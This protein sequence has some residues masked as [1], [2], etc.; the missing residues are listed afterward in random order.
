MTEIENVVLGSSGY[1]LY[2]SV[3]VALAAG[4]ANIEIDVDPATRHWFAGVLYYSDAD[5]TALV[6]PTTGTVVIKAKSVVQPQ[7]FQVLTNGN[8]NA[9]LVN[10]ADWSDNTIQARAEIAGVDVATH[11]RF[12]VSGNFS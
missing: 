11:V 8:L 4:A 6:T 7:G 1:K 10:Q 3:P 5:G 2:R 9:A 12:I